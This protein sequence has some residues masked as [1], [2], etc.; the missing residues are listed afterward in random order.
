[1]GEDS[2]FDALAH[3]MWDM[4][5]DI[6]SEKDK[7]L[8]LAADFVPRCKRQIQRLRA[9]YEC[10][11]MD[12]IERAISDKESYAELMWQ[13]VDLTAEKLCVEEEKALFAVNQIIELWDGELD[14]LD[15][16]QEIEEGEEMLFL[17]DVT[18]EQP[19]KTEG[20]EGSDDSGQQAQAAA[21]QPS[22]LNRLVHFWC[23]SD[24]EE[25]RPHMIAC[26]IGWIYALLC[27]ALGVFMIYEIPL[28]DK[29]AMPVFVFMFIVLTAKRHYIYKSAG[30]LSLAIGGF[31]LIA[32]VRALWGGYG[33]SLLCLPMIAAALVVFNNGRF[34]VLLDGEKRRASLAYLLIFIMSAAVAAGVYAV[35]NLQ[36]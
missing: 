1:M 6:F 17:Q 8:A 20:S 18:E 16:T 36:L 30:R 28:G 12:S 34:A 23:V 9:M 31:Y 10:G 24:C 21:E 3:I 7:T 22:V 32:G 26:P 13:A 25:G 33:I 11:A 27:A 14:L 19:A 35:Q 2:F 15:D 5:V 4:E 29:L